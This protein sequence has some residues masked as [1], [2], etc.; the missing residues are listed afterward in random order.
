MD[1]ITCHNRVTHRVPDPDKAISAVLSQGLISA[2]LPFI[3]REGIALLDGEY[4]DK[5]VGLL[6]IAGLAD[7]YEENYPEVYANQIDEINRAISILQGIYEENV[8]PDQEVD[9]DTHPDNLG[10]KEDPGCFRCHDGKHFSAENE[11]IRLECNICHS[12]PVVFEPNALTTNIEVVTG[13]E[14]VSHTLTTWIALHGQI[15]DNS[16]QACH[17]TPEGLTDL[18]KLEGKP[19]VDNSFCGNEACHGSAWT[20]AEFDSPALQPIL[21]E[22]LEELIGAIPEPETHGEELSYS[23]S[24]GGMLD[25]RCSACHGAGGTGGLDVTSYASLLAGGDSGPG[26]TPGDLEGSS[27]FQRQTEDTA[28]YMQLSEDEIQLLRE[29][30]L[31][32]ASE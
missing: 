16:C 18:S 4:E 29:W 12:I 20:Y 13:P 25:V 3:V 22:Q 24:I 32:G 15:K 11:A 7:F 19:E 26:V 31:A 6:V 1:C 2:D 28:H 23:G 8:F 14:P 17:T 30:I 9:W 27:V 5:E 21:S 10:H